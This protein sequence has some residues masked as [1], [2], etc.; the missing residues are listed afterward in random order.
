MIFRAHT[1]PHLLYEV[2]AVRDSNALGSI[3]FF[4]FSPITTVSPME[5]F[6][7]SLDNIQRENV[8]LH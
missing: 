3:P 5:F 2:I 4:F 1:T 8:P 7:T 6:N